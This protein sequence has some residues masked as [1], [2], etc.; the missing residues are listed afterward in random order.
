MDNLEKGLSEL[1]N[2]HKMKLGTGA[3]MLV[4]SLLGVGAYKANNTLQNVDSAV[5]QLS[6]IGGDVQGITSGISGIVNDA[7]GISSGI[8]GIVNDA[9][10]ISSG[11]R[12]AVNNFVRETDGV[13]KEVGTMLEQNGTTVDQAIQ[14]ISAIRD[15]RQERLE[16][17]TAIFTGERIKQ[18]RQDRSDSRR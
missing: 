4:L 14:I 18:R 16:N 8:N 17:G 11:V 9:Q 13:A 1:W 15:T 12:N 7:Q 5:T 6:E 10:G 2:N 3:L